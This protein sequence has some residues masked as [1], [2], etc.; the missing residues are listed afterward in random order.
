[1][2][3]CRACAI[4]QVGAYISAADIA[5]PRAQRGDIAERF[6]SRLN[7]AAAAVMLLLAASRKMITLFDITSIYDGA[8]VASLEKA[9]YAYFL[10]Q[11]Q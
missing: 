8:S 11:C 9:A 10:A 3:K 1:M 7:T 5:S 6:C 2:P 4:W